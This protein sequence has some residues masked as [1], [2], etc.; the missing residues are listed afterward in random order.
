MCQFEVYKIYSVKVQK[1]GR[2]AIDIN[3]I[4]VYNINNLYYYIYYW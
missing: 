4:M 1:I 2:L 3:R